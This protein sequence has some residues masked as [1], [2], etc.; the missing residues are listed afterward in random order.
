MFDWFESLF[1]F[2][3][4]DYLISRDQFDY[5]N[6]TLVS[7]ANGEH[8]QAG[9]FHAPSIAT[10]RKITLHDTGRS[11]L[12]HEVVD[13][14]LLLHA[15]P[16]NS[17][18]MF[19]VASQFNALE[20]PSPDTRPEDGITNYAS[21]P[22]QGPACSLAAAAGTAFRNYCINLQ[23]QFGQTESK[24]LNNLAGLELSLRNG[25]FWTVKNGYVE[26]DI[27]SLASFDVEVSSRSW[28]ELVGAIRIGIQE[29]T[30]V[31]FENRFSR[32][33]TP[34]LVNQAFCAA[35]SC[36]YSTC[37][38]ESWRNLAQ[39][40]LDAAYEG[41]LLAAAIQRDIGFGSGRVWLTFVGG[42]A[43][44]NEAH[45]IYSAMKRALAR[46]ATLNLDIRICHYQNLQD[47]FFA[48]SL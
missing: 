44:R 48:L 26:S 8:F 7:R 25:P 2:R 15:D 18:D 46:A 24:Q 36:A 40:A 43:F 3:E 1:G 13:D 31:V 42:G 10:L 23:T 27:E 20:F 30:E 38:T 12:K 35:V 11:T 29:R 39:V 17:L 5:K 37:P 32:L 21:D 4:D 22:T 45:W 33:T 9:T 34:H 19:Q 28:D 41:T 16:A 14:A 6:E 47:P